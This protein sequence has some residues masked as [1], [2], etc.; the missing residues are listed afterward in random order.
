MVTKLAPVRLASVFMGVWLLA[1]SV[2]QY[3]GGSLG[4]SWG[5]VAPA[6]YFSVFVWTSLVGAAVLAA[7]VSPLRRLMHE[8]R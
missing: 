3:A 4:E 5:I 1:S 2:G 6:Q 8:V 7:L